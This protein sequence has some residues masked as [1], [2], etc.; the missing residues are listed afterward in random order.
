M[1]LILKVNVS[2]HFTFVSESRSAGSGGMHFSTGCISGSMTP[3]GIP[4]NLKIVVQ[5][6]PYQINK[7]SPI[8]NNKK[9][10]LHST[11]HSTIQYMA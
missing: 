5:I 1:I 9:V 8:I 7:P 6:S 4:P 2:K 3:T 10:Y 11:L